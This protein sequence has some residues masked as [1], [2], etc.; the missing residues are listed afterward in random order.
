MV[1]EQKRRRLQ[2]PPDEVSVA[3]QSLWPRRASSIPAV[4]MSSTDLRLDSNRGA[5]HFEVSGR[6]AAECMCVKFSPWKQQKNNI[7]Y[8][9]YKVSV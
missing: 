5:I 7:Y 3:G 2:L 1:A 6:T 4:K 9:I 8:Y